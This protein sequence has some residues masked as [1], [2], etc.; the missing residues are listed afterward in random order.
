MTTSA[1]GFDFHC[2]VDLFPDPAALIADCDRN[3][4]VTL[5]VTTTPKAWTQNRRWTERSSFVIP[6]IGLHPELAA[7]RSAEIALVEQFMGET[8][9]VG[10]IGLDGSPR[11]RNTLPIQ[12]QI[13]SRA[14]QSA[15]RLGAR[16]LTIH[17]RRAGR[18]VL[19]S[20][21]EHTTPERV[22]PILHWFSDSVTLAV[23]AARFGC[24][25][26]IN[27][28]MLAADTGISL[29]RSLPADRLLT[30][31][32]AP[33]TEIDNR[34]S[35]PRDVTAMISLLAQLR[36]LSLEEMKRTVITNAERVLAFAGVTVPESDS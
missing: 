10:E 8:P 16:V 20:L 33:F 21:A 36:N 31:T 29:I 25:F 26:S 32:D 34:K 6:A 22:L 4:I 15:E 12:K 24:Y 9:F 14:L 3:R 23:E 11:H 7:Q 30:E 28:R 2:H 5:A 17:S 19:A 35:E 18:E 27:H 1:N 13:F